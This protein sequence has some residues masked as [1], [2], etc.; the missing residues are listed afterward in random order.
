M[1]L[2][3]KHRIFLFVV[4]GGSARRTLRDARFKSAML[5]LQPAPQA[6]HDVP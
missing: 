5:E 4:V 3:F 2:S 6:A 1:G